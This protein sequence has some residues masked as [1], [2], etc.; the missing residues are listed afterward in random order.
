MKRSLSFVA[1]IG[2]CLAWS[3]VSYGQIFGSRQEA[4]SCAAAIG[5]NLTASTVSVVCGIPPE[6][7]DTLIKS[8][9]EA[10]TEIVS[11]HKDTISLLKH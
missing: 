6:I 5:G 3:S 11:A 1:A 10:L 9:T 4:T 2:V 7:L 8:R